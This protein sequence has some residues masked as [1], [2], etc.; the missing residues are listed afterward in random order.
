[1][2]GLDSPLPLQQKDRVT[3]MGLQLLSIGFGR[4]EAA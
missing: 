3:G 2:A 4:P 1:M